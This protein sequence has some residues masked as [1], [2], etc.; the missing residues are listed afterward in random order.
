MG[1]FAATATVTAA[2]KMAT[3]MAWLVTWCMIAF[4]SLIASVVGFLIRFE[5]CRT[6]SIGFLSQG[7]WRFACANSVCILLLILAFEP[8]RRRSY[9]RDLADSAV[10]EHSTA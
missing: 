3:L 1:L 6:S 10:S 2:T 4:T 9:H 8:D 5:D 7:S